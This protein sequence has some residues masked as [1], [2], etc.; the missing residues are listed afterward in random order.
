[1]YFFYLWEF[2]YVFKVPS[3]EVIS[4]IIRERKSLHQRTP[5]LNES[6]M[7]GRKGCHPFLLYLL[8]LLCGCRAPFLPWSAA[9]SML[10]PCA[11]PQFPNVASRLTIG[12]F[13]RVCRHLVLK[14]DKSYRWGVSWHGLHFIVLLKLML[15]PL[16]LVPFGAP[17]MLLWPWMGKASPH[18]LLRSSAVLLGGCCCSFLS[19]PRASFW[20]SPLCPPSL[21]CQCVPVPFWHHAQLCCA[22][23]VP[24]QDV[25]AAAVPVPSH[26]V[27]SV[28]CLHICGRDDVSAH[29]PVACGSLPLQLPLQLW[30]SVLSPATLTGGGACL[31]DAHEV[32]TIYAL[33]CRVRELQPAAQSGHP[34]GQGTVISGGAKYRLRQ[35][36]ERI[37]EV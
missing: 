9:R 37:R 28:G 25:R 22:A 31:W 18:G 24:G 33:L 23:G 26:R 20:S 4:K 3:S 29:S 7:Q 6:V 1:M 13:Q 2:L 11:T 35:E 5:N 34:M 21:P 36:W 19:S 10:Q 12:T 32:G 30:H 14:W 17:S 16:A 8:F 15:L 27:A